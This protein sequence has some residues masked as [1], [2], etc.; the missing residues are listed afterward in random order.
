[1]NILAGYRS[2]FVVK[3]LL[4]T[5]LTIGLFLTSFFVVLIPQFE[6]IIYGRKREMIRELTNSA[7][8]ILDHWHQQEINGLIS[9]EQAQ[10]SAIMQIEKLRYGEGSKD[11]FWITDHAP[12]M[13]MHPYR[14]DLNG[15]SL[16]DFRDSYGKR[17]FVEMVRMVENSNE[18]FVDYTWQWKDDSTRIVPKLSFVKEYAP[19]MWIIGTGIYIEDVKVEMALLEQQIT[20]ISIAITI[21]IVLLL[22]FIAFQN[23]R[24]ENQRQKAEQDLHESREKYRALVETSTEG[25]M[26]VMADQEIFCNKTLYAMLGYSGG[27]ADDLPFRELF[28][29][30]PK[31]ELFD[32][33]QFKIAPAKELKAEQVEA[34]IRTKG[35]DALN[36][37]ISISPITLLKEEGIVLS[38]KDI[39]PKDQI[40]SAHE[41]SQGKYRTL[42][43]QLFVGVFRIAP[44]KEGKILEMNRAAETILGA[45][46][47]N[48]LL[49]RKLLDFFDDAQEGRRF[50]DALFNEGIVR[51]RVAEIRRADGPK[52][53]ISFSAVLL[54]DEQGKAFACDG[55]LE[56]ISEQKRSESEREDVIS[57]LRISINLL[58]QSITPFI[59]TYPTCDMQASI[60]SA[61]QLMTRHQQ[62][63]VLVAGPDSAVI[64]IV[65]ERDI[66]IRSSANQNQLETKVQA[67]MTSP[68]ICAQ[69]GS[70]VFD[71][72]QLF[73][74]KNIS[75]AVIAGDDNKPIGIV[76]ARNIQ[77]AFYTSYLTF[78]QRIESLSSIR[79][80]RD[81]HSRLQQFVRM[82]IDNGSPVSEI[83]R[84]TTMISHALAKRILTLAM[85]E[86]GE[87]PVPFM[88]IELG[89]S[90]RKEQ[91]LLTDQDNAIVYSDPPPELKE[92][93]EAYFLQLGER[94]CAGL[95]A[96]GY[97][98]CKGG[99]MA[100]NAKWCQPLSTWK[101]YFTD[102]VTAANPQNI[103][104]VKIF[105][106][107]RFLYGNEE[108]VRSLQSHV[109][110]L[111]TGNDP[112]ILYLS[113]SILQ[114]E[115][116][117]G[118]QKLKSP[119]DIKK[120]IMP[121]VDSARLGALKH[122]STATNTMERLKF[123]YETGVYS[124]KWYQEVTEL[125]SFLMR[126]RFQHQA[127]LLSKNIPPNNEIEPE[128]CSEFELLLL[129]K[130]VMQI[131]ALKGMISLG[132]K[133]INIR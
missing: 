82:I 103:L 128:E 79:E 32:F 81:Y 9:R 27:P 18:G 130:G 50:F 95:D 20:T 33:E 37:L 114:W 11:Y 40:A 13:I 70:S 119:F 28:L 98:F 99:I 35:G 30:P 84:I 78:I 56:D 44:T 76:H 117:E 6:E 23:F 118:V 111:L 129:K 133:G 94:L 67:V 17:L 26:L 69:A 60:G 21:T 5:L 38:I 105:F 48:D 122:H 52:A 8:N 14:P 109:K 132:S 65:T 121:I 68:L 108:L 88:F 107:F 120:V 36:V 87:P 101:E 86:M 116:P 49:N 106:D 43:N 29:T 45:A 85:S 66:R 55:I 93:A 31:A 63:A 34:M 42:A 57:D 115:L 75:H 89:S 96:I 123:L 83:T 1:M 51:Q 100:K 124:R 77:K 39:S 112:F 15:R 58:S 64:G 91:T 19:W 25:L 41:S 110:K 61:V 22:L 92:T 4:P 131:E 46:E 97:Q 7:W 126:K 73:T 74:E 16:S 125:Y 127:M 80:L 102:W 12:I 2:R 54:R 53:F 104:D 71:M 3:T 59:E 90:G 47:R 113:E 10:E 62:D 72:L 24:A